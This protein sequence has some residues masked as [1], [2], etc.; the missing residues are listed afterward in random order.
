MRQADVAAA[1]R[2]LL[3]RSRAAP[4]R[5]EPWQGAKEPSA[6]QEEG[7]CAIAKNAA[8]PRPAPRPAEP[9]LTPTPLTHIDQ[10]GEARMVDVSAKTP[11][12][13]SRSPKA[14]CIMRKE[15]LDLVLAGNAHEGRRAGRR[16]ARRHHGGQAH[17][18]ADPAL[19]SAADHQGRDRHQSGAR[20]AR[21]S[22][23]GDG[24]SDRAD[25]RRDGGADGGLDRL[26]DHLRHG[27][28]GR[29]RHAHRGHPPAAKERRQ[30]R[31]LYARR[32]S[33]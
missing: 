24:E 32:T 7:R 26:P 3:A 21:L 9:A 28:G 27:Q 23:A 12:S 5:S 33:A 22:G 18:R 25:R 10:R 30:V 1:T 31:R 14:A 11:P 2:A 16:A 20:A 13:A 17:A 29:A 6:P 15:T 19:P 4:R 8:K